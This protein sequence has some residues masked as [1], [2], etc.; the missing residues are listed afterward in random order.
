MVVEELCRSTSGTDTIAGIHQRA[1]HIQQ[2]HLALGLSAAYHDAVFLGGQ[3]V[4]RGNQGVEERLVIVVTQTAHFARTA[5][6]HTQHGIGIL[7]A[8]KGELAGLH[9]DA[10]DVERALVGLGI[11]G[12]QHDACGRLYEVALQHLAHKGEAAAGTQV[13]FN[14][15]HRLSLGQIL[16]IEGTRD[17]QLFGNGTRNFLDATGR[18]K[19]NLLCGEHHGGITTVYAG[20]LHM[21]ADGIFHHLAVLRH[22]VKLNLVCFLQKFAHHHGIFLAHL[23]CH[24]QKAMELLVIVAHVHGRS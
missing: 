12:V 15:L 11:G 17:V 3:L 6:V 23:T 16:D 18:G 21:L 2:C 9:T 4:A 13:A 19:G 1:G 22:S 8:C 24:F 5:H 20:I 10:V 14:D 7:Q